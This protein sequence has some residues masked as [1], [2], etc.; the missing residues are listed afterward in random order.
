MKQ[1]KER[2]AKRTRRGFERFL[3]SENSPNAERI[4]HQ[5]AKSSLESERHR[6]EP[7]ASRPADLSSDEILFLS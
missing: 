4:A 7:S 3:K 2:I 5:R 6:Q 1:K